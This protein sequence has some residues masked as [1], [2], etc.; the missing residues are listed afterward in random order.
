[1]VHDYRLTNINVKLLRSYDAEVCV[2]I[3]TL[4]S[5]SS[6]TTSTN[7]TSIF[8]S[9]RLKRMV[10]V[11]GAGAVAATSN[12]VSKYQRPISQYQP[13]CKAQTK[14]FIS[15]DYTKGLETAKKAPSYPTQA[16]K[17]AVKIGYKYVVK[18]L[19]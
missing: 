8:N 4:I 6:S 7:S 17:A 10:F 16:G 19:K 13:V 1:M 18:I 15:T 9:Y 11:Y 5:C 14:Q 2:L 3:L 12:S